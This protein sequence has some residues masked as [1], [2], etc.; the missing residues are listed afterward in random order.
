MNEGIL[1]EFRKGA[2]PAGAEPSGGAELPF[3]GN[4]ALHFSNE[5]NIWRILS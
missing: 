1:L 2:C 5:R 4:A 3:A